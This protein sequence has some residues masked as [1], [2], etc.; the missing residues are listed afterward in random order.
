M[1]DYDY[2]LEDGSAA[3][4]VSAAGA[5]GATAKIVNLGEGRMHGT[6]ILYVSASPLK[7]AHLLFPTR[8]EFSR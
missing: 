6:M 1:F 5:I 3:F 4:T 7:V 2:R 8:D